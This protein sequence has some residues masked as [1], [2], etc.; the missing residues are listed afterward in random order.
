MVENVFAHMRVTPKVMHHILLK[1]PLLLCRVAIHT[2]HRH[3]RPT[4]IET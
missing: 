4:S 3:I 2:V 1:D